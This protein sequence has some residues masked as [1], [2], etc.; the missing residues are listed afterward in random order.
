VHSAS[1]PKSESTLLK[2]FQQKKK[3][4]HIAF[5]EI[6]LTPSSLAHILHILK[7]MPLQAMAF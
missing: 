7:I 1:I 2:D 3:S 6:V 4:L 5:D